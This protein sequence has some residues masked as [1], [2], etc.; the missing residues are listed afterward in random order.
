[1]QQPHGHWR[2]HGIRND[3]NGVNHVHNNSKR[4]YVIIDTWAVNQS[5]EWDS[6]QKSGRSCYVVNYP[7]GLVEPSHRRGARSLGA[8]GEGDLSAFCVSVGS[9]VTIDVFVSP[10]FYCTVSHFL[11]CVTTGIFFMSS[12]T[13]ISCCPAISLVVDGCH[14]S[15]TSEVHRNKVKTPVAQPNKPRFKESHTCYR[16]S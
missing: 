3:Y 13:A 14:Y 9:S 10:A 12:A 4:S 7:Q 8:S 11:R 2:Q 15:R 1:M 16:P 5:P 6:N